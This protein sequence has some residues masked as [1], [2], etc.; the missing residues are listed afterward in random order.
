MQ[1]TRR[2]V[3]EA[4]ASVIAAPSKTAPT[5]VFQAAAETATPLLKFATG[6]SNVSLGFEYLFGI[7]GN[8]LKDRKSSSLFEDATDAYK[9]TLIT[10]IFEGRVFNLMRL[11]ISTEDERREIIKLGKQYFPDFD[12]PNIEAFYDDESIRQKIWE[13]VES[14]QA[15]FEKLTPF[16]AKAPEAFERMS[17]WCTGTF[18]IGWAGKARQAILEKLSLKDRIFAHLETQFYC[19]NRVI[20]GKLLNPKTP[21]ALQ[22][23]HSLVSPFGNNVPAQKGVMRDLRLFEHDHGGFMSPLHSHIDTSLF[24]GETSLRDSVTRTTRLIV[25]NHG[26]SPDT[27]ETFAESWLEQLPTKF[28]ALGNVYTPEA[29]AEV[30][31]QRDLMDRLMNAMRT[32]P[33]TKIDEDGDENIHTNQDLPMAACLDHIRWTP[34]G[35]QVRS[36]KKPEFV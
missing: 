10:D 28:R 29:Y 22:I 30:R 25:E 7:M 12:V 32:S 31:E 4:G 36:Y 19:T 1:V 15:D 11:L 17:A 23:L 2:N 26:Y 27:A 20:N 18:H 9:F 33:T 3:L 5:A 35:L 6:A 24:G 16:G 14:L 34:Y 8:L 13:E 21:E